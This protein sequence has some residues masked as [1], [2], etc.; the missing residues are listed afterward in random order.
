MLR[1]FEPS[2]AAT[3]SENSPALFTRQRVSISPAALITRIPRGGGIETLDS[4]M[5]NDIRALV[6]GHAGVCLNQFFT[7]D[8]TGGGHV[9]G[10]NPSM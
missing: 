8:N 7:R 3:S 9:D 6:R 5:R 4:S 10:L 2:I 1:H